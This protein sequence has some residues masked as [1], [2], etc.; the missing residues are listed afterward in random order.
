MEMLQKQDCKIPWK[1]IYICDFFSLD[2]VQ[3][4]FLQALAKHVD[5]LVI[6]MS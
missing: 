2:Q 5:D 1:H 4:N 6:S 3:I